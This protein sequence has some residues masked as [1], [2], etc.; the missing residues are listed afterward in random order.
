MVEKDY[1]TW[2]RTGS[3]LEAARDPLLWQHARRT[4]KAWHA[5]RRH[6]VA[7]GPAAAATRYRELADAAQALADGYTVTLTSAALP[8]LL[9]LAEHARKHSTRL[10]ATARTAAGTRG[11]NVSDSRAEK[12]AAPGGDAYG[13]LPD[14]LATLTRQAYAS[15]HR[16]PQRHPPHQN[17]HEGRP[18]TPVLQ[19]DAPQDCSRG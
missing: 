16:Q 15:Q 9:E 14:G 6:G 19:Q 4:E 8:S 10:H 3:P 13:A 12:G 18:N 17:G 5:V 2:I 7:D 1:R 11:N